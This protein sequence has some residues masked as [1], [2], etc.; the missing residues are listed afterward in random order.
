MLCTYTQDTASSTDALSHLQG[1]ALYSS[2]TG[3]GMRLEYPFDLFAN[4]PYLVSHH[5]F[6]YVWTSFPVNSLNPNQDLQNLGWAC[7]ARGPGKT[8]AV[9]SPT[10]NLVELHW[11]IGQLNEHN[12]KTNVASGTQFIELY[13]LTLS[14]RN[15]YCN[16]ERLMR[17]L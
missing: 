10:I 13:V 1:T 8:D 7:V 17:K 3:E 14:H 9:A 5:I 15:W 16:M 6:C 12:A 2:T 11:E 4:F